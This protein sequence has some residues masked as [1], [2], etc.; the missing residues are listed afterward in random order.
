MFCGNGVRLAY[1]LFQIEYSTH[2]ATNP[3]KPSAPKVL[4]TPVTEPITSVAGK[5]ATADP[6][7]RISN[8]INIAISDT[9]T[10]AIPAAHFLT[11]VN[12]SILLPPGKLSQFKNSKTIK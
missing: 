8:A 2:T 12:T 6:L 9:A 11:C 4:I 7:S 10:S 5:N 1:F 3:T